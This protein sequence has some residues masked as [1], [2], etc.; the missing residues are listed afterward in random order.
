MAGEVRARH[1]RD[2]LRPVRPL[3]SPTARHRRPVGRHR[4]V[5]AHGAP[6]P[7]RQHLRLRLPRRP[8]RD[9]DHLLCGGEVRMTRLI[10][11]LYVFLMLICS[12][13]AAFA[14]SSR[15]GSA[16]EQIDTL[17]SALD[18]FKKDN[19]RYPSTEEGLAA[20]VQKPDTVSAGTW[21]G[22]YE[23]SLWKD[24]WEHDYAY[25]FPGV[26]NPESFD[27]FSFGPDGISQ[28]G[29]NDPDDINNWRRGSFGTTN[30]PADWLLTIAVLL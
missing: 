10:R 9:G 27:L 23:V 21:R 2:D 12:A 1:H 17:T 6:A 25:K 14:S 26:H 30:F 13:G 18:L 7:N 3:D 8:R 24:P 16:Q 28:S 11:L 15:V 29:G 22:P 19:G 20:L 4:P 5:G